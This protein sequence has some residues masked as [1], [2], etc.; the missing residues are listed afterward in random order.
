MVSGKKNGKIKMP[1]QYKTEETLYQKRVQEFAKRGFVRLATGE[2]VEAKLPPK[3]PGK[4][5]S[6]YLKEIR[7]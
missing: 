6:E 4:P 5:L 1:K 3:F 7:E 2:K